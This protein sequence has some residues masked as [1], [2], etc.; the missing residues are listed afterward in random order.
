M[1]ETVKDFVKD[2]YQLVSANTPTV[3]L[4]G[5]DMSNGIKRLNYLMSAYSGTG[6]MLTVAKEVVYTL[7][8]NQSIITFGDP[9]FLPTPNV[10]AGRLANAADVWLLLDGVTYPL[11]IESR[12][13]F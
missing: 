3:P 7:S 4:Q 8:I 9:T 11:V 5:Y 13:V 1:T 2:S 6:L 10:T 12:D